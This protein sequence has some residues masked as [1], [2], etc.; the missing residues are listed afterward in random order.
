M[1]YISPYSF[2]CIP[3]EY[4]LINDHFEKGNLKRNGLF[5]QINCS[6]CLKNH[7]S[8]KNFCLCVKSKM[9]TLTS[10]SVL[11]SSLSFDL[12]LPKRIRNRKRRSRLEGSPVMSLMLPSTNSELSDS[13][14]AIASQSHHYILPEEEIHHYQPQYQIFHYPPTNAAPPLA[15]NVSPVMYDSKTQALVGD[16]FTKLSPSSNVC[17]VETALSHP[18]LIEQS[19]EYACV[20]QPHFLNAPDNNNTNI[21]LSL[22]AISDHNNQINQAMMNFQ[23]INHLLIPSG[24]HMCNATS[25]FQ[26]I[27][28][29]EEAKETDHSIQPC[30]QQMQYLNASNSTLMP[31]LDSNNANEFAGET[32]L[33]AA[34]FSSKAHDSANSIP[35]ALISMT[36]SASPKLQPQHS[37]LPVQVASG[38]KDPVEMDWDLITQS[39]II[40][41][42]F[43]LPNKADKCKMSFLDL[44]IKVGN[45]NVNKSEPLPVNLLALE[46]NAIVNKLLEDVFRNVINLFIQN[47][48]T[49][50][51]NQ[52]PVFRYRYNRSQ[53]ACWIEIETCCELYR[54]IEFGQLI[55]ARFLKSESHEQDDVVACYVA[56][57]Q[58]I[59]SSIDPKQLSLQ[60]VCLT[61]S[62]AGQKLSKRKL[63]QVTHTSISL[64]NYIHQAKSLLNHTDSAL[65]KQFCFPEGD[66]DGGLSKPPIIALANTSEATATSQVKSIDV[67]SSSLPLATPSSASTSSQNGST[68]VETF[69][70][71][72]EGLQAC[73]QTLLSQLYGKP[74]LK[75][76]SFITILNHSWA[77]VAASCGHFVVQLIK[78]I[79]QNRPATWCDGSAQ[80]MFFVLA[81]DKQWLNQ[82]TTCLIENQISHYNTCTGSALIDSRRG[83]RE[84]KWLQRI[85]SN[86]EPNEVLKSIVSF[87][88]LSEDVPSII[89]NVRKLKYQRKPGD[90]N[91][92]QHNL[93]DEEMRPAAFA[94]WL[95]ESDC[96]LI[97]GTLTS[98]C[99]DPITLM[100]AEVFQWKEHKR[101]LAALVFESA[102]F[103]DPEVFSMIQ[104]GCER[105]ILFDNV[106]LDR[107][108]ECKLEIYNRIFGSSRSKSTCPN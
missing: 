6:C 59:Q 73:M 1:F 72:E 11:G 101:H 52:T 27:S 17:N 99:S 8:W 83:H 67:A 13:F 50:D 77:K 55:L 105:F 81:P 91:L 19:Q 93:I 104:F 22:H 87:D 21:N 41:F 49:W 60:L 54:K 71:M 34:A 79:Q 45:L 84:S 3:T 28:I 29:V 43:L 107:T 7:H 106:N 44:L 38:A 94:D 47:R 66:K 32:S 89:E 51:K 80:H 74:S 42:C 64:A 26:P 24:G 68:P 9:R 5:V 16:F 62:E 58:M 25:S 92:L 103:S 57:R 100:L 70:L 82:L 65:L 96:Q 102:Q 10:L 86:S 23:N 15:S 20:L 95:L 90:Y 46:G 14:D 85:V 12:P 97:L 69:R 88:A 18:A 4:E 2:W 61:T 31:P 53:T 75:D 39:S 76:Q 37:L 98:F 35:T 56:E 36:S 40:D 33:P 78:L 30:T 108:E 63:T 48:S